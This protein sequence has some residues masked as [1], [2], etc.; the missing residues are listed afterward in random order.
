M[1]ITGNTVGR[2]IT[3]RASVGSGLRNRKASG[4]C[5]TT[6]RGAARRPIIP[7]TDTIDS[8]TTTL[9]GTTSGA[10]TGQGRLVRLVLPSRRARKRI[11]RRHGGRTITRHVQPRATTV[12]STTKVTRR[13]PR[14]K[15]VRGNVAARS[16]GKKANIS[17]QRCRPSERQRIP[18]RVCGISTVMAQR[19]LN[20]MGA[21]PDNLHIRVVW[22][23]LN[24]GN[25]KLVACLATRVTVVVVT[26]GASAI[27]VRL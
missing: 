7:T 24:I 4:F 3:R 10:S 6:T 15:F 12:L 17:S 8:A 19:F 23:Q 16:S 1:L 5:A 9:G 13:I 11:A 27:G 20:I 18:N 22:T 21:G 25:A 26:S 2:V 14:G